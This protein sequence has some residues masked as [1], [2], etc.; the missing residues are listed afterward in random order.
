MVLFP[1]GRDFL[2]WKGFFMDM[3]FYWALG[4]N[5][6]TYR[7]QMGMTQEKLAEKAQISTKGIQKVEAGKSGMRI[8]TFIQI[9]EALRVSMDVLAGRRETDEV[10]MRQQWIFYNLMEDKTDEEVEYV[11]ELIGMIFYLQK[12]YRGIFSRRG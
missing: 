8:D 10:K 12:K 1:A 3:A 11:L 2:S 4:N 5:V 6:R 7:M 9:A